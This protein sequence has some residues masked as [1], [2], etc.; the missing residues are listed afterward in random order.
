MSSSVSLFYILGASRRLF[1]YLGGDINS[2][3]ARRNVEAVENLIKNVDHTY[4]EPDANVRRA[5][6]SNLRQE[7]QILNHKLAYTLATRKTLVKQHDEL[8]AQAENTMTVD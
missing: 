7:I 1:F 6:V 2:P 8:M 3:Q 5:Q 4:G